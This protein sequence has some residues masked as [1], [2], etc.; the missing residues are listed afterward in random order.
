MSLQPRHLW[1]AGKGGVLARLGKR[2]QAPLAAAQMKAWLE[3]HAAAACSGGSC[4]RFQELPFAEEKQA[5]KE[6]ARHPPLFAGA[7]RQAGCCG[8]LSGTGGAPTRLLM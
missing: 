3:A 5:W 4:W 6:V 1:S 7:A 8:S 2:E